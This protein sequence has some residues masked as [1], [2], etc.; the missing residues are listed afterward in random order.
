MKLTKQQE[1]E[2]LQGYETYWAEYLNGNVEAMEVLLD[3]SYTQVGSAE[4]EVFTTK[5]EAIQM[6]RLFNNYS[7]IYY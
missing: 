4:S 1:K 6:N 3:D 2:L 5:K 7:I